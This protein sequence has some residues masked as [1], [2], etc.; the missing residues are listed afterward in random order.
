MKTECLEKI[1]QMKEGRWK[2]TPKQLEGDVKCGLIYGTSFLSLS[3]SIMA[4]FLTVPTVSETLL[5]FMNS[6]YA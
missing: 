6:P 1:R 2:R 4:Y 3:T 5:C